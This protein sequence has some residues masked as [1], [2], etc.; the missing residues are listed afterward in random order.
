M[1]DELETASSVIVGL[2]EYARQLVALPS[3][4][5]PS[6]V[7]RNVGSSLLPFFLNFFAV[8]HY[9]WLD[10]FFFHVLG[11]ARYLFQAS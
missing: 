3:P 8:C 5:S 6:Y 7:Q 11:V 1:R 2:V 10:C 9:F 4:V